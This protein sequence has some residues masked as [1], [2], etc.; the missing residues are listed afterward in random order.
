MTTNTLPVCY[1]VSRPAW[2]GGGGSLVA[3]LEDA[4]RRERTYDRQARRYGY[5]TGYDAQIAAVYAD[6]VEAGG[7][8]TGT[9]FAGLG[10]G[11]GY[12][13]KL[14][15]DYIAGLSPRTL[16]RWGI[17]ATTPRNERRAT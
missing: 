1:F 12:A 4:R 8:G 13:A 7:A 6:H 2:A 17:G 3:S 5:G 14:A 10:V 9:G 16:A 11:G 15:A